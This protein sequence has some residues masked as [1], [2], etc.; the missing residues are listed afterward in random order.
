MLAVC[1]TRRSKP[2][3]VGSELN[4]PSTVPTA[5]RNEET[6]ASVPLRRAAKQ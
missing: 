4:Y 1:A 3:T 6:A 5:G 2:F